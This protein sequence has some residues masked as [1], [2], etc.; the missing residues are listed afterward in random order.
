[1]AGKAV[2][3]VGVVND[4]VTVGSGATAVADQFMV[5]GTGMV[6]LNQSAQTGAVIASVTSVTKLAGPYVPIVSMPANIVAGTI[7]FLKIGVDI[8]DGAEIKAGDVFSLVGNVAGVFATMA[9]LGGAAPALVAGLAIVTVI[10]GLA[11]VVGSET[12]KK[13]ATNAANFFEDNPMDSYLDYACAPN[14]QIVHRNTLRDAYGNQMLSCHWVSASGE[15]LAIPAV[16]LD[17]SVGGYEQAVTEVEVEV[18]VKAEGGS[19]GG[20]GSRYY[21]PTVP[22]HPAPIP[23]IIP[24]IA[25][26]PLEFGGASGATEDNGD[27]YGCCTGG[28]DG[29]I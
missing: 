6:L 25:I 4:G 9:I 17:E 12:I 28:S 15:L 11:S 5:N 8:R 1:M 20:I 18:E 29:Y 24:V 23:D 26:G 22:V 16:F 21:P 27:E 7:T 2:I 3:F 13:I 14:M 19:S 10:T